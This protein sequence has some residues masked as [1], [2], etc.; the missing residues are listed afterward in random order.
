MFTFSNVPRHNL[1]NIDFRVW[2]GIMA[3]TFFLLFIK[4]VITPLAHSHCAQLQNMSELL[5][6]TGGRHS[7]IFFL[8]HFLTPTSFPSFFHTL[9][10]YTRKE[11]VFIM[12]HECALAWPSKS[13]WHAVLV[14]RWKGPLSAIGN[15]LTQE[16]KESCFFI[17]KKYS[18]LEN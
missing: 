1:E 15:R 7:N 14:E 10:I 9:H 17:F 8:L 18:L 16:E 3:W 6:P 5:G 2:C 4:K 11:P 13:C 12:V